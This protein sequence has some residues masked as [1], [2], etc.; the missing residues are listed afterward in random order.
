LISVCVM[1][2]PRTAGL[3]RH[4]RCQPQDRR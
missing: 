4:N 1:T 2:Q 3:T